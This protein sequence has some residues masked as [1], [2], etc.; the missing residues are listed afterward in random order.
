MWVNVYFSVP[1]EHSQVYTIWIFSGRI[2]SCICC[3]S[4]SK[5]KSQRE[6]PTVFP[7]LISKFYQVTRFFFSIKYKMFCLQQ[8]Y[9]LEDNFPVVRGIK[10]AWICSEKGRGYFC[11]LPCT[12]DFRAECLSELGSLLSNLLVNG[13]KLKRNN[14]TP[15]G[16]K[17][18]RYLNHCL[19]LAPP[20]LSPFQSSSVYHSTS[21]SRCTII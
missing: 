21:M 7:I 9:I 17:E 19:L 13:H 4:V 1:H 15:F 10:E 5:I 18:S 8:K 12:S 20:T 14:C 3:W 6:C 16:I 11:P 2:T